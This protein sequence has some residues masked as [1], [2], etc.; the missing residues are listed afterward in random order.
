MGIKRVSGL[1]WSRL[2]MRV[3]NG[4]GKGWCGMHNGYN[5]G[6]PAARLFGWSAA[7]WSRPATKKSISS[8]R[9]RESYC[10]AEKENQPWTSWLLTCCSKKVWAAETSSKKGVNRKEKCFLS[11]QS[12]WSWGYKGLQGWPT[13]RDSGWW[14]LA[15]ETKSTSVENWN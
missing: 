12:R 4:T 2:Q 6:W 1:A 13:A 10:S 9:K 14:Q 7:D 3:D 8:E 15:G 5:G 11:S